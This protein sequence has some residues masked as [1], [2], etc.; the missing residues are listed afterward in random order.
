MSEEGTLKQHGLS[1]IKHT[2]VTSAIITYVTNA[3]P[4]KN[5]LS[6]ETLS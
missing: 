5:S 4:S 6:H 1:L 2:G 3:F